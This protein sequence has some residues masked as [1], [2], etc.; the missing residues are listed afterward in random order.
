MAEM[1][2][3]EVKAERAF[4]VGIQEDKMTKSETESLLEELK[5]LCSTL[6]VEVVGSIVAKLREKSAALLRA[7]AR[8]TR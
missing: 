3:T 1:K 2:D 4:L 8:L 5:G 6:G 7:R